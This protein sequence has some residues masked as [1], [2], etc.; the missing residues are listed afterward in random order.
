MAANSTETAETGASGSCPRLP[1]LRRPA[2]RHLRRPRHV[3]A[4][5][6]LLSAE[7][8]D[9][10]ETFYPLHVWICAECLLVQLQQYVPA[11]EIFTGLRVLLRVLGRLGR[12]RRTLR[13][14]RSPSASASTGAASCSSWPRTTA[15]SCSTS[16]ARDSGARRRPGG[17][18][19]GGGT[20]AGCRDDRR[21]LRH[22]PRAPAGREGRSADLV[23]GEQRARAGP[24]AQRLRCRHRAGA[25][26]AR[27]RHGR[28]A[29]RGQAGRRATSST[30]STTSTTRTSR[31]RHSS[32][33]SPP[34]D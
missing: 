23:V 32:G 14:Y 17:E 22:Q 4:L 2:P 10:V 9:Q 6:E 26:S 24:R 31:S 18:R 20:R 15:T 30:R 28:G 3:A 12:P 16:C 13:G 1:A 8:L 21:L 11:S 33:S 7:E 27:R 29:A 19:R 25:G 34:T 5:R